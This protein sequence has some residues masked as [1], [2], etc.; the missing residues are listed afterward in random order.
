MPKSKLTAGGELD[1]L[2]EQE[3]RMALGPF[4]QLLSKAEEVNIF[5]ADEVFI[6]NAAGVLQGQNRLY[7]CPV[8]YFASIHRIEINSPGATGAAPLTGAGMSMG[9]FL[10]D[11]NVYGNQFYPIPAVG[12]G[13]IAP[14][15]IT[16]GNLS[17]KVL[18]PGES[19]FVVGSGFVTGTNVSV[20]LQIR[21]APLT[22]KMKGAA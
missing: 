7:H 3:L 11:F 15:V 18:R 20:R 21:L 17:A 13:V 9:F 5:A 19:V 10:N 2:N 1:T 4:F 22:R 12:G 6:A 14:V 16:E 8:G